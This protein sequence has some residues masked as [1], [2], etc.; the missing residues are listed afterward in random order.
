MLILIL[1]P[2]QLALALPAGLDQTRYITT[3]GSFTQFVTA[4]AELAVNTVWTT[5]HTATGTFARTGAGVTW[6]LLQFFMSFP[7]LLQ[8]SCSDWR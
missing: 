1:P 4:E 3:H 8:K 7:T 5:C 2:Y 6:L